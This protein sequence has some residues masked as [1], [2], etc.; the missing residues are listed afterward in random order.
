MRLVVTEITPGGSADRV[1]VHTCTTYICCRVGVGSGFHSRFL[2]NL[3]E[4]NLHKGDHII[5]L[6]RQNALG[7]KQD[8]V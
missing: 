1:N 5:S 3:Q 2:V 8:K 4:S 6:D 7:M